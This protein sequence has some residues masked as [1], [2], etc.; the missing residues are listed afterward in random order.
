MRRIKAHIEQYSSYEE[1][2]NNKNKV[3]EKKIMTRKQTQDNIS[4]KRYCMNESLYEIKQHS[5]HLN[6]KSMKIQSIG[7]QEQK[8]KIVREP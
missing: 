7:S 6:S 3:D 4:I 2:S 5:S 1:T 8:G